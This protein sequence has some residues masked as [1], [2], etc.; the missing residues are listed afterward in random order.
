MVSPSTVD[1]A[2]LQLSKLDHTQW[3]VGSR[4]IELM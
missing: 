3:N 4:Y 2:I 1:T